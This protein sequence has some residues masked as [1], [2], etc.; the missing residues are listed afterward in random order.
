MVREQ[1]RRDEAHVEFNIIEADCG[2]NGSETVEQGKTE[3]CRMDQDYRLGARVSVHNMPLLLYVV[4]IYREVYV[5][6]EV[7]WIA[8][9]ALAGVVTNHGTF[10]VL[11]S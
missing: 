8:I 4:T 1:E 7:K 6:P 10:R 3:S 2:T 9:K 11:N 5:H